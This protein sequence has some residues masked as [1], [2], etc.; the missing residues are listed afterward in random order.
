M[1][2]KFSPISMFSLGYPGY[3]GEYTVQV[4]LAGRT[5]PYCV[6]PTMVRYLSPLGESVSPTCR[7]RE[8]V[9]S[10]GL[11]LSPEP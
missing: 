8:S 9:T 2:E 1:Y 4:G 6:Q 3:G 7:Y 11:R 10:A 5:V